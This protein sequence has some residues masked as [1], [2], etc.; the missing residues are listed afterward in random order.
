MI[1]RNNSLK[2]AKRGNEIAK[3]S[4]QKYNKGIYTDNNEWCDYYSAI[5]I[6][7]I[8]YLEYELIE[9]KYIDVVKEILKTTGCKFITMVNLCYDQKYM[10]QKL[11]SLKSNAN[12]LS[13]NEDISKL[14]F[15][16]KRLL[17]L[18]HNLKE[19]GRISIENIDD[20]LR[21]CL[22]NHADMLLCNEKR[23]VFIRFPGSF[24]VWVIFPTKYISQIKLF[25]ENIGLFFN[26]R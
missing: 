3:Y 9:K 22:R 8:T 14:Y 15:D 6:N 7:K 23:K 25:T 11:R 21:I 2:W 24:Y 26:P 17:F 13:N 16:D 5:K 10:K 19:G 12:K 1:I 20:I 18:L 4:P